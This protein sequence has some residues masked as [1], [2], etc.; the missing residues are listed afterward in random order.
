MDASV[1][2]EE[3]VVGLPEDKVERVEFG[4]AVKLDLSTPE[5][6]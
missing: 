1:D 2:R 4:R 6:E 5:R 3:A